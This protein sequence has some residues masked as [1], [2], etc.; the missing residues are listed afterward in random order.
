MEA[1][2]TLGQHIV[3]TTMDHTLFR[4]FNLRKY[5]IL[6]CHPWRDRGHLISVFSYFNPV[7]S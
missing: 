5:S 4:V 1:K 2:Q 7:S 6:T 3:S